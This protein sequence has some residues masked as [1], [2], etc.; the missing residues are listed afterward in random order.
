MT[1]AN[2]QAVASAVI[3]AGFRAS[4]FKEAGD[5]KV[6]ASS[7]G[8]ASFDVQA[9]AAVALANAQGV[10]ALVHEVEFS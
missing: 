3:G 9:S 2:A 6:R 1:Q 7:A 5:W 8:S 10:T 4:I